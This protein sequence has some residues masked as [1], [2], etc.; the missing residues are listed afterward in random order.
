MGSAPSV[1]TEHFYLS[2]SSNQ[3][4]AGLATGKIITVQVWTMQSDKKEN[5]PPYVLIKLWHKEPASSNMYLS[6]VS[7]CSCWRHSLGARTFPYMCG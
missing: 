1:L 2:W 3:W 7:L 5:F 6:A 4:S